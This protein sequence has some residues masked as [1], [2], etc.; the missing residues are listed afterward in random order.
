MI[1]FLI[2]IWIYTSIIKRT[3][4]VYSYV[5]R[6]SEC[7]RANR[8]LERQIPRYLSDYIF[9]PGIL[10]PHFCLSIFS[11]FGRNKFYTPCLKSCALWMQLNHQVLKLELNRNWKESAFLTPVSSTAA[12]FLTPK[13]LFVVAVIFHNS[14]WRPLVVQ[15]LP[16]HM[17]PSPWFVAH[18]SLHLVK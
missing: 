9:S 18:K 7:G 2:Y 13:A 6:E 17:L 10:F 12:A 5:S 16:L 15:L 3:S 14:T 11:N 1:L 4:C 8:N